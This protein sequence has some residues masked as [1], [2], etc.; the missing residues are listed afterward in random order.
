MERMLIIRCPRRILRVMCGKLRLEG[1]F[2]FA[3]LAKATP[4]FVGA[5]LAALTGAAGVVAV[6]RIF[7]ELGVV[8]TLTSAPLTVGL[9]DAGEGA[10]AVADAMAVD[11]DALLP[12]DDGNPVRV[13]PAPL[14]DG[15]SLAHFL[16]AHPDPLTTEELAPLHVCY[17]DF[18]A[19]L[20]DVQPSSKREGF[21][22]VPDVSWADVGALT[23]VRAELHMALVAPVRAPELFAALGLPAPCGVLLWGPPGCGKTLLAKAVAA[24][25]GA[26]FI[27]VKGPEL[28]NKVRRGA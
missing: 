24:E 28:L 7:R 17:G 8:P 6:K 12:A 11:S 22:T 1:A 20:P 14:V 4:G 23:G 26:S 21:A 15:G 3:A 27:S 25:S 9:S 10:A 19:A 2:D 18:I 16:S 5:D 13:E